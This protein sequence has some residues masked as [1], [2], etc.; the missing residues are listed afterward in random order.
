MCRNLA[1]MNVLMSFPRILH[2]CVLWR[3]VAFHLDMSRYIDVLPVFAGIFLCLKSRDRALIISRILEFPE[4]VQ[5]LT[6][7]CLF[8]TCFLLSCIIHMI[9]VCIQTTITKIFRIF[10]HCVIKL[11]HYFLLLINRILYCSKYI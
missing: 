8:I 6:I 3:I 1:R 7:G 10:Y 5:R 2:I 9:G 4:S 11:F